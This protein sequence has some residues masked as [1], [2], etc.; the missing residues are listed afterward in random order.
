M[1]SD[2]ILRGILYSPFSVFF[3][4]F[5][6]KFNE[7]IKI[8][9]LFFSFPVF[10]NLKGKVLID[11]DIVKTGM[12]RIGGSSNALYKNLNNKIVWNNK[13]GTCVFSNRNSF[14]NGFALEIGKKAKIIFGENVYFGPY[15]RVACYNSIIV[16][17]RTRVAWESIILDTD[18]HQTTDTVT[19]KKSPL[20]KPII[21]GT[22]N[23]IG[24]RSM[25]MKGSITPNYTITS[26]QSLLNKDYSDMPSFSLIGGTPAKFIK[27]NIYREM[28]SHIDL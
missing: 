1:D 26:A 18:F 11:S 6:L 2:N 19:N 27:G 23:W 10:Y 28:D 17:E 4:F 25:I 5:Y 14:L 24:T 9:I 13:G 12:I 8:P 20:T 22:N 7:A 3:N 21:I 15:V 16:G